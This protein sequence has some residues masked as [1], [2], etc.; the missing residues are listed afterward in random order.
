MYGRNAS[1]VYQRNQV[2]TA[3]PKKLV[4]LLLEGCIKNLKL[5][6]LYIEENNISEANHALIKAQDIIQELNNTLDFEA[7]GEVALNLHSVYD[8]V[9]NELIQA[10]IHKSVTIVKTCRG[11]IEDLNA[12]WD[13][14]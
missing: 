3:S 8:Y 11:L 9:L 4:T 2:L 7:G 14:L 6:E 5:A 1:N 10:N 12:T 13:Q